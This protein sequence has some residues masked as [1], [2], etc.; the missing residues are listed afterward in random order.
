MR[1]SSVEVHKHDVEIDCTDRV[2]WPAALVSRKTPGIQR[3]RIAVLENTALDDYRGESEVVNVESKVSVSKS[4]AESPARVGCGWSP[5][6][7][8]PALRLMRAAR[9]IRTI[10]DC[11]R[12]QRAASNRL[13]QRAPR[14]GTRR[15]TVATTDPAD[16]RVIL[17]GAPG[18]GASASPS[19]RCIWN[20]THHLRTVCGVMPSMRAI[21]LFWCRCSISNMTL[22]RQTMRCGLVGFRDQIVSVWRSSAV[23]RI[24]PALFFIFGRPT[25]YRECLRVMRIIGSRRPG[26]SLLSDYGTPVARPTLQQ[27]PK[28]E[29]KSWGEVQYV[30]IE[31]VVRTRRRHCQPVRDRLGP[32]R[33]GDRR[34]LEEAE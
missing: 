8:L 22:A 26:W 9:R 32:V 17:R 13:V 11:D 23:R 15:K 20:L 24:L 16:S 6:P 7:L 18:R 28:I 19:M 4:S 3:S 30:G 5:P 14:G 10:E 27:T 12:P 31:G 33:S 1:K 25:L 2:R 21:S 34:W 29:I